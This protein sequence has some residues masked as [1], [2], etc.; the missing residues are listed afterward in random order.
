MHY[1]TISDP[2]EEAISYEDWDKERK[3]AEEAEEK[4]RKKA[5]KEEDR[6]EQE[7]R[8]KAREAQ[9]NANNSSNNDNDSDDDELTEKEL[10]M[11]RGYKK[12]SDGRTTSYFTRE[13]TEDE[14]KLI[15]CIKPKRLDNQSPG[16]ASPSSPS[17]TAVASGGGGGGLGMGSVWNQSGTT[18]EEKDTTDWCKKC[19]EQCLLDTTAA[20]YS[21]TS[22][23]STYVA[24]VKKVVDMTGDASVA[25]AGG[26]KRY[27]YDFHT[28]LEYE[29][30]DEGEV[31][32]ASG[33]LRL[34]DVNSATTV[35]EDELEVDILSWKKV[36]SEEGGNVHAVKDVTE[37]RKLLVHDVRKAVLQF[38]EK[39]NTNF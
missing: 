13:Q 20:Y 37:C 39:F 25:I 1:A 2:P 21:T 30:L 14:K 27:I 18:W 33:T 36:P 32:I 31:A 6:K 24:V 34:P 9:K 8:R 29:V 38:V 26:K 22:N 15:G 19:L 4:A 17:P 23:D 12:T 5:K 7:E 10:A 16:S 28:S 35:D 11:L 3:A